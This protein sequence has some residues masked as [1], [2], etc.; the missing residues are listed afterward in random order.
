MLE[1]LAGDP[2][3][4]KFRS[5]YEKVHRALKKS[6]E[7]EKR[8]V[9]KCRELNAELVANAAKVQTALK[10]S[11]EDQST[12]AALKKEIE[13]AWKM[14]DAS[15]DK[16]ARAKETIQQLKLETSNLSK[17]VEQGAGMNLG[18]GV[19]SES[20]LN[21]LLKEKEGLVR[22]RDDQVNQI[23]VLRNEVMEVQEKLR[24]AETERLNLEVEVGG[25]RDSVESKR[26]EGVREQRK[27]DHL[28]KE[29]KELKAALETKQKDIQQK[30]AIV[31]Q[32]EGHV[33]TLEQLLRESRTNTYKVTREFNQVSENLVRLQRDLEESNHVNVGLQAENAQKLGE[34]KLKEDEI[35][36]IRQVTKVAKLREAALNRLRTVEKQKIDVETARDGLKLEI[37]NLEKDVEVSR[38]GAEVER[39]KQDELIRERDILN[40]LKTQAENATQRQTDLVKINETTKKNLE[41]EL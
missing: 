31:K 8:L 14:V 16:E 36:S 22:E 1:D 28:E 18:L 30:E 17:L 5:E 40:K 41:Q 9:K 21:D 15:H 26:A 20:T 25:L 4:E 29:L 39:K 2:S 38:K 24:V 7:G 33:V 37:G 35:S 11:E 34:I 27:M 13:K 23:V 3:L 10:L 6:H 19:G 32:G 12:I